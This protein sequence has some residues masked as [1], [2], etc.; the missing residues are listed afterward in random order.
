M[1]QVVR[2][3][4]CF[5]ILSGYVAG[6]SAQSKQP[7]AHKGI[8]DL[9]NTDLTGKPL[10]LSGEWKF[11]WKQLL[12]PD[13]ALKKSE[14]FVNYPLLWNKMKINGSGLSSKGFATYSLT[15]LLPAQKPRLAL[16]IPDVYSSYK[17]FVNGVLHLQNGEPAADK[18]K[19][20]PFWTTRTLNLPS[21]TDT[22]QLV[23]Q[24]ANYWHNKG[25]TYKPMVLGT[26]EAV[27]TQYY[28]D[29][30]YDLMLAGCL[31]MGGLFFLGLFVFGR[32]DK[33]IL[34]FS[35]FC[36]TYSY[37]MVGT[38]LYVLHALFPSLDWFLTIRLEYITLVVSIGLFGHYTRLLYPRDVRPVV[39]KILIAICTVYS[40]LIVAIPPFFF[41]HLLNIFL[42][43]GFAYTAYGI[44]VYV[45][46]LRHKRPGSLFAL[47]SS[48]VMFLLF[49][50]TNL[51][52]FGVINPVKGYIF[53]GYI[54]FFFLQSM[55]LSHR[56]SDKLK[57]SAADAQQALKAKSVFLSNMSHEIRTPLNSVIGMAH[58]LQRS[59]PRPDQEENLEVLMFAADNLLSIVNNI[60]DY[61]KI[62]EGKIQFEKIAIDLGAI[63]GNI[64]AGL[65]NMATEKRIALH[66]HIDSLLTHKVIADPTRTAQVMNNLVHNAIK[67]TT[68][69]S[70]VLDIRV[71]DKSDRSIRLTFTVTD[72]GIGIPYHKQQVIFERF[73]QADTSTSR[74]YGGTGLGLAI[75]KKILQ[76]QGVELKL[77]SNPGEGSC[78][79]FTQ[80]FELSPD[81]IS[82]LKREKNTYSDHSKL[83]RG[84]SI[85]L[86]EDN[87]MNVLVAQT[88]LERCGAQIDVASNGIEALGKFNRDKHHMV[89]MD[90]DMPEMDGYETTRQL[91]NRGETLP[92]IALTASVPNEV[93]KEVYA[94]GL[95]NIIVKPFNPDDLFRV[96][97]LYTN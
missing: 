85:L 58:L 21:N 45:R 19:A 25:G 81:K 30:A 29:V 13:S 38:D 62:E 49:L 70:V 17:F 16:S 18:K 34:F 97:L 63:A 31:F 42:A 28:R 60:L 47:L 23:L 54:A 9:R 55:V 43:V 33:T 51:Q 50:A 22:L 94:A 96:L 6:V 4:L 74:K 75:S 69:G 68:S 5:L 32:H 37:R 83:F 76:L 82:G 80:T 11:F 24:V 3:V 88:F 20:I 15:I 26:R 71:D 36:I 7:L 87:P 40:F 95:T 14:V 90:L 39:M 77:K 91:R 48:G 89:L 65:Q 2:S 86:V 92:V 79:Y 27:V 73:T 61:N 12:P 35:L 56:F 8:L 44:Y 57:K 53:L 67:F 66:T 52:Y 93:E 64:M 41:T 1:K 84:I 59:K 78:F 10:H 72:T 46:A